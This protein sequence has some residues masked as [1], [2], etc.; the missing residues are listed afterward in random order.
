MNVSALSSSNPSLNLTNWVMKL[1]E[2]R[3]ESIKSATGCV[4]CHSYG[5]MPSYFSKW[6]CSIAPR[7]SQPLALK[8]WMLSLVK[9][10]S[11]AN[12]TVFLHF[13]LI[14]SH[15]NSAILSQFTMTIILV[16]VVRT[17]TIAICSNKYWC[18]IH[19]LRNTLYHLNPYKRWTYRHITTW[20]SSSL[21]QKSCASVSATIHSIKKALPEAQQT[22]L[23][24]PPRIRAF[25]STINKCLQASLTNARKL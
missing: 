11:W 6:K 18:S 5:K 19:S 7:K 17:G 8:G 16:V 3:L 12:T 24:L 15:N 14:H 1:S 4:S 9:I 21:C 22:N 13:Q 20:V 23:H 2:M 25:I 10:I